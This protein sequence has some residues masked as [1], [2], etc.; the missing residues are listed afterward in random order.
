MDDSTAKPQAS[1]PQ[2]VTELLLAWRD[3]DASALDRLLPAV[4]GDLR[5]AAHRELQK[6][7]PDH[8]LLTI[9]LVH[10]A[11]LR[12]V[13]SSRVQWKSRAHFLAVAAQA[14]RRILV[15]AARA[16]GAQ[17]RGGDQIRVTLEEEPAVEDRLGVDVVAL[18]E[19]LTRL[20]VADPRRSQVVEMRFFGG[21]SVEETA[22]ALDVSP[23]TVMRDWK[24]ARAW[25]Y[26]ELGP[27]SSSP[28]RT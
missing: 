23:E 3:G 19:A 5:R 25:L 16:R 21:L 10:E 22:E 9:D 12:L 11:Y 28:S 8:T 20:A 7:R 1:A 4:Y 17:K 13:D 18:D 2:D 26:N 27:G 6:E 14:M 24:V 15:D